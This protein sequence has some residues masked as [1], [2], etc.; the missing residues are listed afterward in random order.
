M[1]VASRLLCIFFMTVFAMGLI[2]CSKPGAEAG[3]KAQTENVG[4][5]DASDPGVPTENPY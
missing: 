5:P 2:A 3:G 4:P 1:N